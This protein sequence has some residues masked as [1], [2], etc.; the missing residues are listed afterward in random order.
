[1]V[2]VVIE[3]RL[4]PVLREVIEVRLHGN[5]GNRGKTGLQW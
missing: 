2:T 5:S 4:V 1:M 3:V